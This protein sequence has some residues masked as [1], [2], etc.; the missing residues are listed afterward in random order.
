MIV[1][2]K[3]FKA[4]LNADIELPGEITLEKREDET[5]DEFEQRGRRKLRRELTRKIE[6]NSPSDTVVFHEEL[7]NIKIREQEV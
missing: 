3:E 1:S 7:L 6:R 4:T 2:V 5:E